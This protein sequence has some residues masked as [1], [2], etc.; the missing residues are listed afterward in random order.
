M[1]LEFDHR[2]LVKLMEEFGSDEK[3]RRCLEQLRWSDG[4][5]CPRCQSKATKIANREQFDCDSC[6]YQFSVTCGTIFHD[7]HLPLWKWF[8]ATYMITESRKGMSAN[9]IKRMLGVTYKTAWYLCHRIRAAMVEAHRAK[10]GG[11]VEVDETYMGGKAHGPGMRGRGSRKEPVIG[12][13]QRGGELRF[14][15]SEDVKSGTLEKYIRENIAEDVDV[16]YTDEFNIYRGVAKRM[17]IVKKHRTIRHKSGIYVNGDTH[18]N[19]VESAFSLLKRGVMGTWH[20]ISAK[21][22]QA[23]CEEMSFRF[24]NRNNAFLFRDTVLKLIDAPALEYK[25]LTEAA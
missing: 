15:H 16:L 1:N 8:L 4:P 2:T 17:G 5:A 9:Q 13:P 3:C 21:H 24:N 11:C 12:I 7:S 22:L 18:A 19:T 23:Y 20:R 25:K 6:H 10:L 14:F